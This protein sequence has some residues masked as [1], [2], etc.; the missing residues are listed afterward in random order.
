MINASSQCLHCTA[1]NVSPWFQLTMVASERSD[2]GG[3]DDDNDVDCSTNKSHS[4]WQ[5]TIRLFSLDSMYHRRW[6]RTICLKKC[7]VSGQI[8]LRMVGDG[9]WWRRSC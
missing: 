7:F 4:N 3:G 5:Q 8:N 9:R 2:G 1:C 6:W